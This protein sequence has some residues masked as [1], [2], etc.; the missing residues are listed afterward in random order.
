MGLVFESVNKEQ[1][2]AKFG[3]LQANRTTYWPATVHRKIRD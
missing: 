1:V 3:G 2:E